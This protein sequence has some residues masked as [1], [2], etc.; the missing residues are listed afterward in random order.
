HVAGT[1][2]GGSY[3]VAKKAKIVGV[4]VLDNSGFGTTA[5]V[6]AGIDWVTRNAVKPAVANMSL[7]GGA[8]TALDTA[9]RNSI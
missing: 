5:Q 4:R 3:G 8:D 6:V 2:A 7:G 1:L 9:V